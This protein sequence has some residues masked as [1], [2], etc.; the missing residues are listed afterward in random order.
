MHIQIIPILTLK[1]SV[2][3][4]RQE[5]RQ[6][7]QSFS[8]LMRKGRWKDIKWSVYENK[9]TKYISKYWFY[10]LSLPS[11][12]WHVPR[13]IVSYTEVPQNLFWLPLNDPVLLCLFEPLIQVIYIECHLQDASMS[14]PRYITHLIFP[15]TR[16]RIINP[17]V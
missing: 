6:I 17:I 9:E 15:T 10:V 14:N 7:T 11:I 12:D 16:W 8:G 13:S 3:C 4:L 1:L 5:E 2:K